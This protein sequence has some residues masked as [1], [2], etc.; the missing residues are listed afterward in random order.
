MFGPYAESVVELF[1]DCHCGKIPWLDE[2]SR[3][4]SSRRI[5]IMNVAYVS[6]HVN[7]LRVAADRDCSIRRD[8]TV[9]S[10]YASE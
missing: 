8:P 9:D 10:V 2:L 6:I 7:I 3:R 4:V 1:C 5:I